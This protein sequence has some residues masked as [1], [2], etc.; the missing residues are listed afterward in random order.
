MLENRK[1]TRIDK[2]LVIKY[3]S[4]ID[5]KT[6]DISSV[7]NISETGILFDTN[8]QF[9]AG[10]DILVLFKIPLDPYNWI[11]ANVSVVEST[12]CIGGAF[13]TRIKFVSI[14][15]PD[16]K[17]IKDY[18]AWFLRNVKTD[19]Q[20]LLRNEKRKAERIYKSLIV[21]YG[22]ENHL[23]VVEK[24]DITTVINFSKKGM[25]FTSNCI[26]GDKINFMIK[27]P[28]RPYESLCICGRIIE[29]K[30]LK[31]T[32]S[33]TLTG[34][35]ITRVEF[36]DLKDEQNK[37]LCDYAEWLINNDSGRTNKKEDA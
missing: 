17:M 33:E 22:T 14:D 15:E 37:L 36:V 31:L 20:P 13:L 8:R 9:Q 32:N 34:T 35:F 2:S 27:L 26:C 24:W 1:S 28:S 19:N 25:V 10:E 23:G 7:K 12:P 11:E 3:S 6:W 16:R 5:K 18:V 21:S 4:G 30:A 29:S